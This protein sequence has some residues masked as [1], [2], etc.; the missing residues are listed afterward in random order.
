MPEQQANLLVLMITY[1]DLLATQKPSTSDHHLHRSF[2]NT[3]I[4][5]FWSSLTSIFQQH[6]NRLIITYIDLSTTRK[7]PTSD[8]HLHRSFNNTQTVYFSSSLTSTFE[9]GVTK[10]GGY[11]GGNKSCR[12]AFWQLRPM[13]VIKASLRTES[14]QKLLSWPFAETVWPV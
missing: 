5:Q 10:A 4:P 11:Q 13:D 6:A 2:N 9:Q 12:S 1:T 7:S 3:Q 14:R 8:N